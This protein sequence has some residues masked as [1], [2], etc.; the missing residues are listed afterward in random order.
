MLYLESLL[1]SPSPSPA[2]P[3]VPSPALSLSLQVIHVVAVCRGGHH[4][5]RWICLAFGMWSDKLKRVVSC[6]LQT[7][8]YGLTMIR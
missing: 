6:D 5:P 3:V 7:S 8:D 1:S 2:A 4:G